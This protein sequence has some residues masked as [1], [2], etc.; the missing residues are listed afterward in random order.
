MCGICITGPHFIDDTATW[1]K[2]VHLLHFYCIGQAHVNVASPA[3]DCAPLPLDRRMWMWLQLRWTARGGCT[4]SPDVPPLYFFLKEA[5]RDIPE[6]TKTKLRGLSPRA[7]CTHCA[8]AACRRSYFQLLRIED[9]T[10]SAWRIP[11]AV[12]SAFYTRAV[13]F[14]FK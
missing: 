13:T 10:W 6:L 7:N 14:S 11:T 3:L 5:Y 4:R 2:Q 9:A 12:F 8:T 1:I